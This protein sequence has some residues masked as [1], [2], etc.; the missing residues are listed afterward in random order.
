M[1]SIERSVGCFKNLAL[2][3]LPERR[4]AGPVGH[5]ESI[6]EPVFAL[7]GEQPRIELPW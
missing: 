1:S 3:P 5:L 4:S 2:T 6:F 7:L